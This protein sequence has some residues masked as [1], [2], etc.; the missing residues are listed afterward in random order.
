VAPRVGFAYSPFGSG[1]KS[2]IRGGYAIEYAPLFYADGGVNMGAGIEAARD[3]SRRIGAEQF[4]PS[5]RFPS[6][7]FFISCSLGG[8]ER[9]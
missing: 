8:W 9:L 6:L 5:K 4:V 1:A 7:R 2:V 3:G